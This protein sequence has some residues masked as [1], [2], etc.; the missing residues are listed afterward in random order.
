MIKV[1][2][3][4]RKVHDQG[5]SL[6][7]YQMCLE[8]MGIKYRDH[9]FLGIQTTFGVRPDDNDEPQI[10]I[11][12]SW[13][14]YS[15]GMNSAVYQHI[16]ENVYVLMK[17]AVHYA[18][19][20]KSV[21]EEAID[22]LVFRNKYNPLVKWLKGIT[23]RND[24]D[25]KDAVHLFK[26]AY[27]LNVP[28]FIRAAFSPKEIDQY[29]ADTALMIAKGFFCRWL[30][31]G[32]KDGNF[33]FFP[34]LIGGEGI[35]K[36]LLIS[37]LLPPDIARQGAFA[38]T[39]D[40]AQAKK[41]KELILR[42]A[43]LVECAEMAGYTRRD[44]AEHKALI[45]SRQTKVRVAYEKYPEQMLRMA[46]MFGTSNDDEC[47]AVDPNRQRRNIPLPVALQT[48]WSYND[49]EMN[50][51]KIMSECRDALFGYAKHEVEQG[52]LC[53]YTH[54][55]DESLEIRQRL[56]KSA[57]KQPI[58]FDIAIDELLINK[59][60]QYRPHEYF[61]NDEMVKGLPLTVPAHCHD[62]SIQKM[63]VAN[64]SHIPGFQ[65]K[66]PTPKYLADRLQAKK[67]LNL[68]RKYIGS[69][70]VSCYRPPQETLIE[71]DVVAQNSKLPTEEPD[72]YVEVSTGKPHEKRLIKLPPMTTP[73]TRRCQRTSSSERT[74][75]SLPCTKDVG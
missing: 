71:R 44:I 57:E 14:N 63:L 62:R 47:Y 68:G 32:E 20:P 70:R 16:L 23:P 67:W 18:N 45:S 36:S 43:A 72:R 5:R 37:H 53:S 55:A 9:A 28:S 48:G 50:L 42:S 74:R 64:V 49:V 29:Y 17:D 66:N 35:G 6:L 69:H 22:A 38:D 34:V 4:Y 13:H 46:I 12:G 24:D 19:T 10:V 60:N 3:K 31:K 1:S 40:M 56:V 15:A 25:A 41:E 73:R 65:N 7:T 39:F 54:W 27:R 30:L 2:D 21:R 11:D 58:N 59:G 8:E 52:R 51:P 33:P 75:R 26:K 61:T